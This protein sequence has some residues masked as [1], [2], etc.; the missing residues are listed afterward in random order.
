MY[1]AWLEQPYQYSCRM[2]DAYERW[3]EVHEKD[4]T[5]EAWE[6]F[7]DECDDA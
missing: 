1:D 6:E 7:R 3:L 2:Q 5:P 4:D